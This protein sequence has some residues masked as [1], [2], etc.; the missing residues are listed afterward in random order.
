LL[1]ARADIDADGYFWNAFGH[2]ASFRN[3]SGNRSYGRGSDALPR[4]VCY[5]GEAR[6][7]TGLEDRRRAGHIEF[8]V[9][10]ERLAV[11]LHRVLPARMIHSSE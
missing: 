5:A 9:D 3:N 10:D 6:E 11:D 2:K 4:D 8:K 7:I 1:R